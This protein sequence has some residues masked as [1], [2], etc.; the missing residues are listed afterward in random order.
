MPLANL[1]RNFG[2]VKSGFLI[3]DII[4][5]V[6]VYIILFFNYNG[7]EIPCLRIIKK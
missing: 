3:T 5:F 7:P 1:A 2:S 6:N 4:K